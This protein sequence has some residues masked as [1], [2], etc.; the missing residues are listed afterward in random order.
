MFMIPPD[1]E[2]GQALG[3]IAPEWEVDISDY[4]R[5]KLRNSRIREITIRVATTM[6]AKVATMPAW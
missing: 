3:G 6:E 2:R 4:L 5:V 1:S